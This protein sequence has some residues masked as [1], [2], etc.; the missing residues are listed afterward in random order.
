[1]NLSLHYIKRKLLQD[2]AFYNAP[3][4]GL[5]TMATQMGFLQVKFSKYRGFILDGPAF[6]E[7]I[8]DF[9]QCP[10]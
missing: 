3:K 9:W 1:M 5:Y 7:K 6:L 4:V 10:S 8:L 2:L